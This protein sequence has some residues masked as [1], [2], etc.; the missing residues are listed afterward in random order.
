MK[1]KYSSKKKYSYRPRAVSNEQRKRIQEKLKKQKETEIK[2]SIIL[3]IISIFIQGITFI[4]YYNETLYDYVILPAIFGLLISGMAIGLI[5]SNKTK[6]LFVGI[7]FSLNL[8]IAGF[9][10]YQFFMIE[11][12]KQEEQIKE[13]QMLDSLLEENII[14]NLN[15]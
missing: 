8:L 10:S 9:I 14:Q 5:H 2:A 13:S 1:K 6:K 4:F 7:I 3:V 15:N 11:K 12:E